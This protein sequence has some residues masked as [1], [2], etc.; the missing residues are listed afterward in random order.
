MCVLSYFKVVRFAVSSSMGSAMI[1]T[2]NIVCGERPNYVV[3]LSGLEDLIMLDITIL[4][5][6]KLD[7]FVSEVIMTITMDDSSYIGTPRH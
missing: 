2:C 5:R 6:M 1:N 7:S 3:I 4:C